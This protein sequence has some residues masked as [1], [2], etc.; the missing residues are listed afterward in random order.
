MCRK[1]NQAQMCD[2]GLSLKL[3]VG[4]AQTL[5]FTHAS[6]PLVCRLPPSLPKDFI[7]SWADGVAIWFIFHQ[8]I[9]ILF[10]YLFI[11]L[12]SSI[13]LIQTAWNLQ[14]M[15]LFGTTVDQETLRCAY[16]SIATSFKLRGANFCIL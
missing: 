16:R 14:P 6:T 5:F 1:C 15:L 7:Y 4:V 11:A 13:G 10:T 2:A 9:R 12:L 3:T 8:I